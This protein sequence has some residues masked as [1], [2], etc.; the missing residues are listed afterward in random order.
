MYKMTLI[1][2]GLKI[3]KICNS[4]YE[5]FIFE[6]DMPAKY[7]LLFSGKPYLIGKTYL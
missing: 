2:K 5:C 3:E 4:E 1:S 6:R 7:D